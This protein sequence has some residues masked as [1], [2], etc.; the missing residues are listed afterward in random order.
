MM[1]ICGVGGKEAGTGWH[2]IAR[3]RNFREGQAGGSGRWR[4]GRA[5]CAGT[6]G[7]G[8]CSIPKLGEQEHGG[9]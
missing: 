3:K 1:A 6:L 9:C 2:W 4:F 5:I 7:G 8:L